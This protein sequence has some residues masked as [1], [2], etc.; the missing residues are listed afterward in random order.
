MPLYY[1]TFSTDKKGVMNRVVNQDWDI[2]T[3]C[4]VRT[5]WAVFAFFFGIE[6]N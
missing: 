3:L 4:T 2:D 6:T 1:Q 5:V